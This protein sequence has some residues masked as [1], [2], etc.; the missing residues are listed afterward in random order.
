MLGAMCRVGVLFLSTVLVCS[1]RVI[2]LADNVGASVARNLAAASA[3]TKYVMFFDDDDDMMPRCIETLLVVAETT[4]AHVVTSWVQV[5]RCLVG[6]VAWC[7]CERVSLADFRG[8][9][10]VD[11]FAPQRYQSSFS[12]EG[13]PTRRTL[14]VWAP[15]GLPGAAMFINAF[16]GGS[17][18]HRRDVFL[19]SGGYVQQHHTRCWFAELAGWHPDTMPTHRYRPTSGGTAH[20]DYELYA[21]EVYA[22]GLRLMVVPQALYSYKMRSRGSIYF[23]S[24]SRYANRVHSLSPVL[25]AEPALRPALIAAYAASDLPG[26][27]NNNA[28]NSKML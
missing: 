6:V 19:K 18:L 3:T 13:V 23:T 5:R 4:G 25:H 10:P 8:V 17:G 2:H 27:G 26:S 15:S 7:M 11:P 24:D 16:G 20:L 21:R 1:C 9:V 14:D 22:E 28:P 12:P